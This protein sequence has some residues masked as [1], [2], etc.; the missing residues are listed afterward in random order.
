VSTCSANLARQP[1]YCASVTAGVTPWEEGATGVRLLEGILSGCANLG[2]QR[3][4]CGH[5]VRGGGAGKQELLSWGECYHCG[6]GNNGVLATHANTH[7][8]LD[9]LGVR[10]EAVVR[11]N[12]L[13]A[14]TAL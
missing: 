3:T 10:A 4:T 7:N 6:H 14:V 5:L 1:T 2:M 11:V 8:V 12:T 13:A 9:T